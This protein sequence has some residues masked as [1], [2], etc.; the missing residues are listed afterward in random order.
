MRVMRS[1]RGALIAGAVASCAF[2]LTT[3]T[4]G[5]QSRE[6]YR[7]LKDIRA[8]AQ[9]VAY[10]SAGLKDMVVHPQMDA[11]IEARQLNRIRYEINDMGRRL[12]QFDAI[13]A[14]LPPLE[15]NDVLRVT[16]LVKHM[17][18]NADAAIGYVNAHPGEVWVRSYLNDVQNLYSEA[19]VTA[20][21]VK[22][23]EDIAKAGLF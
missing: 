8:D 15:R 20:R 2:A 16:P 10:Y 14:A 5:N 11:R 12:Q 13:Q 9:Q 4:A 6:A 3:T 23:A 7:L 21:R 22:S 19:N 18:G 1:L 17:A